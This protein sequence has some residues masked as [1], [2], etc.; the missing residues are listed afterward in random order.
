MDDRVATKASSG[1]ES[2]GSQ[3][4]ETTTSNG[5]EALAE[6]LAC[7]RG[8]LEREDIEGAREFVK[9]LERRWPDSDRAQHFARVL[10]PPKVR[11]VP[12]VRGR[13]LHKEHDW[14]RAHA[15]EYPGC[16]LAVFE[17]R[18]IAASPELNVVLATVRQTPG[19]EDALLYFQPGGSD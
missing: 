14:L 17:D 10:A 8:F 4:A 12:G 18:L 7:L 5:Q 19:A 11:M 3:T 1:S 16:W 13:P 15:S 9:E 6:D 2:V